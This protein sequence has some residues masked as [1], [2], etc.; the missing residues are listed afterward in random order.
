MGKKNWL[1]IAPL[2]ILGIGVIG[3]SG[4]RVN[5][6]EGGRGTQLQ[7]APEFSL[8]KIESDPEGVRIPVREGDSAIQFKRAGDEK[9]VSYASDGWRELTIRKSSAD[10]K[11]DFSAPRTSWK[12]LTREVRAQIDLAQIQKGRWRRVVLHG[13]ATASGN[14]DIIDRY[15]RE[16]RQI[17]GGL[18]YHFVIGNGKG[19]GAGEIEVGERWIDQIEGQHLRSWSKN[20]DSI[21]ICLIGDFNRDWAPEE[22][23]EALDE[24]LDYLQAKVGI[25]EITTH[26]RLSPGASTC[27]GRHFPEHILTEIN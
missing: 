13:S 11:V 15:H 26:R 7:S 21:G 17:Q 20:Q 10:Y 2:S 1:L 8:G 3:L 23:L 27:P 19:S 12:Y 5:P 24:L 6:D 25:V 18:A 16:I 9:V 14:S 4:G 22:Q